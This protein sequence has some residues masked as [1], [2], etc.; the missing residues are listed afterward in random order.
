MRIRQHS[1]FCLAIFILSWRMFSRELILSSRMAL[2]SAVK[3]FK[4]FDTMLELNHT[5]RLLVREDLVHICT[6]LIKGC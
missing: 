5:R 4:L 6:A 3:H 1:E 2:V